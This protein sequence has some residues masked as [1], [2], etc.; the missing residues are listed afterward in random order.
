M[1]RKKQLTKPTF[2]PYFCMAAHLQNADIHSLEKPPFKCSCP[3]GRGVNTSI[4]AIKFV[5]LTLWYNNYSWIL[6]DVPKLGFLL[7]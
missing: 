3:S 7:C 5:F 4:Y 6:Y 1:G 2:A